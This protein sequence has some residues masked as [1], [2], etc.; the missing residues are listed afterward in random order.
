MRL[1]AAL[2]LGLVVVGM[3]CAGIPGLDEAEAPAPGP[4]GE[5]REGPPA[6]PANDKAARE[7]S[8][9]RGRTDTPP[10]GIMAM[11]GDTWQVERRLVR[12]WQDKPERLALAS[13]K[14]VG[15]M[16]KKVSR[17]DARFLGFENRDIV[18]SVNG[19]PLGSPAEA[20]A[21]YAAVKGAD[22]LEVRFKRRGATRTHT[23]QIVD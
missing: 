1:H 21:A 4:S 23:Y 7:S 22:T 5:T 20:A 3:A 13:Q 16:L 17:K 2:G 14:G 18:T 9:S 15:F 11:G 19:K 6:G 10:P 12:T 8:R